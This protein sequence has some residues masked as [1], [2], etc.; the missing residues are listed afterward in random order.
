[1]VK[2]LTRSTP[3][4]TRKFKTQVHILMWLI[5]ARAVP[6]QSVSF[7]YFGYVVPA[8]CVAYTHI[9]IFII[10]V[11]ISPLV[12]WKLWPIGLQV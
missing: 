11:K 9:V 4:L 2:P 10:V 7:V 8:I 1:M 3:G 5:S 6:P 12:H